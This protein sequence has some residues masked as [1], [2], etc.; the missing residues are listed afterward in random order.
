MGCYTTA[1][2]GGLA[3]TEENTAALGGSWG[4]EVPTE[5]GLTAPEMLDAAGEGK[6]DVL[7]SVGG[8]FLDVL[9]QPDRVAASLQ[10][11]PLRVHMDIVLSSQMLVDPGEAVL[12]LPATT[13]YEVPGGVTETT[14]ERR[15]VLS[16]EI[17]GPR[18]DEARPEW[19]VLDRVGG[20][21]EA[22]A[23]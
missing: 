19:S 20:Q 22:A 11:T 7:V 21:G 9:P 1:L 10:R 14:T 3:V 12:L 17:R 15:V 4:F 5:S 6:L 16:P 8:N 13:R 2:P 18:I 23:G